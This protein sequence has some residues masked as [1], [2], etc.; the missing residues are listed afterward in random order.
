[1]AELHF[2]SL[3]KNYF[4]FITAIVSYF[5]VNASTV[6]C[7][8]NKIYQNAFE[9]VAVLLDVKKDDLA[10]IVD[11][12]TGNPFRIFDC[13]SSNPIINID[14]F[15]IKGEIGKRNFS[16]LSKILKCSMIEVKRFSAMWIYNYKIAITGQKYVWRLSQDIL[17]IDPTYF[18]ILSKKVCP[19]VQRVKKN[20]SLKATCMFIN[21]ALETVIDGDNENSEFM[22]VV[23]S[24]D[25][26]EIQ[27]SHPDLF[28]CPLKVDFRTRDNERVRDFITLCQTLVKIKQGDTA[29]FETI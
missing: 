4:N 25:R 2:S 13:P 8:N 11:L 22:N 28:D 29:T 19:G 15:E 7:N 21:Q 16:I 24:Q 27:E 9:E 17:K 18:T 1:M 12:M 10:F 5:I 3:T 6:E 26:S 20:N 14:R 23:R